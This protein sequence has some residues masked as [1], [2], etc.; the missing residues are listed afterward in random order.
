MS[1]AAHIGV[2]TD[3]TA[4]F[5][6]G[7]DANGIAV[8]PL[9][10]NWDGQTFR[11]K[12]DLDTRTFY[13]RL[14]VSKSNPRTGAPSLATY[15]D[16]YRQLL[17]SHDA[18]V[19][20]ALASKVSATYDVGRQAAEAVDPARVFVVDSGTLTA[21]LAW[22]AEAA[23][24]M[25]QEG[26]SPEEIV[27]RLDELKGRMRIYCTLDTLEFLQRGGRIGRARALAGTLLSVKPILLIRDGEVSPV[28]RVRTSKAAIRRLAEI[29]ASLGP[30]ERMA[31]LHG[32]NP[33]G[34]DELERQVQ[35]RFP[36]LAI[37][38]G[39]IGTVLGT[40]AGPGLVG[41]TVLLGG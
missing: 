8:V 23:V 3:S 12:V 29:L 24:R 36:S 17:E 39:E 37:E 2:V 35:P 18:V 25:G 13:E 41:A 7:T 9:V 32:G 27:R 11:D 21:C 22:L 5:T 40:H 6:T 28:E 10:V 19:N 34:A 14:R 30:I 26:A 33:S 16:V 38:R 20:V 31:V 4:D 15:E 1:I